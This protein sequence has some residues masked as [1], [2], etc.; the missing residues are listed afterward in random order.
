MKL[1]YIQTFAELAKS[2]NNIVSEQELMAFEKRYYLT[3]TER[4]EIKEYCIEHGITIVYS[5]DPK[6]KNVS[7]R[8]RSAGTYLPKP[9]RRM[10]ISTIASE[11][12]H[13]GAVRARKRA[14]GRGWLCG[15]YTS[16]VRKTIEKCIDCRFSDDQI[17]YIVSHLPEDTDD[18]TEF[19]LQDPEN[20]ELCDEL[21]RELNALIP[22]IHLNRFLSDFL[23]D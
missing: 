11:I 3:E 10:I 22:K 8:I 1:G 6:Q 18:E 20:Q 5:E 4:D 16:S 15:T 14:G 9:E 23:D 19:A 7:H 12:V 21:S 17:K 13:K 2:R